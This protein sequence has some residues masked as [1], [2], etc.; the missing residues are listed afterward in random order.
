[1][2]RD[3]RVTILGCFGDIAIAIGTHF[4]R[5]EQIVMQLLNQA[6]MVAIVTD[7]VS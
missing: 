1:M 4:D 5:Y 3:V 2:S 6:A 7:P